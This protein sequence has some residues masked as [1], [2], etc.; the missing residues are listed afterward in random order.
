MTIPHSST[1]FAL[2]AWKLPFFAVHHLANQQLHHQGIGRLEVSFEDL[3][4]KERHVLQFDRVLGYT[5][6]DA[7]NASRVAH[8]FIVINSPWIQQL[9]QAPFRTVDLNAA[10][11]FLL[12]SDEGEVGVVALQM[13]RYT[14]CKDVDYKPFALSGDRLEVPQESAS[15]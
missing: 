8:S 3:V 1:S 6:T 11:H 9:Q 2:Q 10:R 12:S 14:R 4:L 13:P 15:P 5:F 7:F